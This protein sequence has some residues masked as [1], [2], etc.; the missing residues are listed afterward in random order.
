MSSAVRKK[1]QPGSVT[2]LV[3]NDWWPQKPQK[4]TPMMPSMI[5]RPYQWPK[6][7][8]WVPVWVG[9]S[10]TSLSA[11]EPWRLPGARE[12]VR[13]PPEGIDAQE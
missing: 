11:P 3:E 12:T 1:R 13:T 4:M 9:I 2:Q 8:I 10:I 5:A 7:S 6:A